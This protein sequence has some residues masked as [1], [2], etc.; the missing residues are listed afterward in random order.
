MSIFKTNHIHFHKHMSTHTWKL[1]SFTHRHITYH[2]ILLVLEK[3]HVLKEF[4]MLK[5]NWCEIFLILKNVL[6]S[7]ATC[8]DKFHVLRNYLFINTTCMKK[9]I[10]MDLLAL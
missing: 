5:K 2:E 6:F 4:F 10:V 8:V 1:F 9:L 7:K 3:L